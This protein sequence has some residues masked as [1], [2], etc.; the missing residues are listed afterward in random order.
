MLTYAIGDIHGRQ[1]LLLLLLDRIRDHA[2]SRLYKLVFLGDYIDRGPESA[3]VIETVLTLQDA[4]PERVVCLM[5][6]HES[7]LLNAVNDPTVAFWWLR[8][9]GDA[10][11]AS[12]G[13][14]APFSMPIHVLEWLNS[15]PVVFE[16]ETHYYVHAGLR[17]G[18]RFQDQSDE[19]RLWIREPF[20]D[21]DWDFGKHVVHGHTPV[22][23]DGPETNPFRTNLDTGA[24]FR[25]VLTAGIF[26]D[27]QG[28]PLG[29][30]N[31][32]LPARTIGDLGST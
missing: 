29:F 19:D 23:T 8:N 24:V 13:V 20:L 31:A 17:P 9:G 28:P 11:L 18:R 27:G 26:H 4:S 25:G 14:R 16:D 32:S 30:I 15:L 10:T 21:T 12:F 3:A 7:M 2:G 6:N 1:D 22:L 5:G